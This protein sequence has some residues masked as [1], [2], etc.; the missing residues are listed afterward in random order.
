M[1]DDLATAS[2]S[3]TGKSPPESCRPTPRLSGR[4]ERFFDKR[5]KEMWDTVMRLTAKLRRKRA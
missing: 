2:Q 5:G 1:I 4:G 3:R